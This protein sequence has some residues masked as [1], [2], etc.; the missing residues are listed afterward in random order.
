MNIL[1][2]LFTLFKIALVLL[3]LFVLQKLKVFKLI[4]DWFELIYRHKKRIAK[5]DRRN[6]KFLRSFDKR[7]KLNDEI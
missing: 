6:W 4:N 1:K 2:I 3:A 5:T 7:A